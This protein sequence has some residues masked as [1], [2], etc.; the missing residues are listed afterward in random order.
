MIDDIK[1]KKIKEGLEKTTGQKWDLLP[2][3]YFL[4]KSTVD[5]RGKIV[6]SPTT[7]VPLRAFLND[8]TSEIKFFPIK[9]LQKEKK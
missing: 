8:K 1:I 5:K 7:G 3:N 2:S 4:R 6:V 9:L